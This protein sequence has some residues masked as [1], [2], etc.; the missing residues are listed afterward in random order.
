[1]TKLVLL[2]WKRKSPINGILVGCLTLHREEDEIEDTI[3]EYI[4]KARDEDENRKIVKVEIATIDEVR[5][6]K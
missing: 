1:M 3:T 5:E 4:A 2:H 6:I